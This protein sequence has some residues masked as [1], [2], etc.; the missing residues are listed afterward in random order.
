MADR[1]LL[2]TLIPPNIPFMSSI[3]G[4]DTMSLSRPQY[5]ET[6]SH[7][8]LR[9]KESRN[10]I[11]IRNLKYCCLASSQKIEAELSS[12]TSANF[13]RLHGDKFQKIMFIMSTALSQS[14]I[15]KSSENIRT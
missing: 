11:E 7:S 13:Y 6:E 15:M 4:V 3:P 8:I 12:E 2:P 9:I 10:R 14:S 5:Q 1:F